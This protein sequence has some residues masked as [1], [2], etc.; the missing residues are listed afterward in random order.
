MRY[1]LG[2]GVRV[3]SLSQT[4]VAFSPRSGDTLQLN[5]EAVAILELLASEPM[6]EGKV[7]KELAE[8]SHTDVAVISVA[9]RHAWE[10]LLQAGLVQRVAV[11][12]HN[13]G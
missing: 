9:I 10:Q 8:D 7:C 2:N 5:D 13:H 4:W 12:A 3:E 6:D 1:S 11:D